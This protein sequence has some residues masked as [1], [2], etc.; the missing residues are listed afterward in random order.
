MSPIY[1]ASK[2]VASGPLSRI[3]TK[4]PRER[5]NFRQKVW[6]HGASGV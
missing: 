1:G 5:H 2:R 4:A 3:S 6:G